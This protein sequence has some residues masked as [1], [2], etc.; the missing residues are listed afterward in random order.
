[1]D[2]DMSGLSLIFQIVGKAKT[3][4]LKRCISAVVS[5]W[6]KFLLK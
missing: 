1:M 3:A 6:L 2:H 5:V 4:A